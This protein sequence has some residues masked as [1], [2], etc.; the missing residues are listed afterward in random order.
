M[1]ITHYRVTATSELALDAHRSCPHCRNQFVAVHRMFTSGQGAYSTGFFR[2]LAGSSG[3]AER[4]AHEEASLVARER[5]GRAAPGALWHRCTNCGRYSP[6]DVALIARSRAG[7]HRQWRSM[8]WLCIIVGAP[9]TVFAVLL[10]FALLGDDPAPPSF[11]WVAAL[12]WIFGTPILLWG[13]W[14][15]SRKRF[16]KLVGELTDDSKIAK[17]LSQWK[18]KGARLADRLLRRPGSHYSPETDAK[19]LELLQY[20]LDGIN[21][22]FTRP[23]DYEMR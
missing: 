2:S 15:S 23:M 4:Q 13:W 18:A 17:W 16:E 3:R 12:A 11:L 14:C 8:R 21:P 9:P 20:G 6:E 19:Q 5:A 1:A 10:T 7:Y 22:Y